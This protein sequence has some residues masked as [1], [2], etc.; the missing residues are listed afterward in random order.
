MLYLTQISFY[1]V[2]VLAAVLF[3]VSLV[4]YL[5]GRKKAAAL[6]EEY[7]SSLLRPR[8]VF[9]VISS[10]IFGVTAAVVLGFVALMAMAVAFM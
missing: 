3:A 2:P 4:L 5:A 6:P 9:L 7:R 10:V 8:L 1:A